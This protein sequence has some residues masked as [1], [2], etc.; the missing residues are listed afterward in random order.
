MLHDSPTAAPNEQNEKSPAPAVCTANRM[1]SWGET[2][3]WVLFCATSLHLAFLQP[4]LVIIPGERAKVLSGL[5]CGL[6]FVAA[7]IFSGRGSVRIN[8]LPALISAVLTVLVML[9]GLFSLTPESSSIRGF[10]IVTSALGGFWCA[11]LLLTNRSRQWQ[12]VWLGV[13]MLTGVIVL[14]LVG[15][16][17]AGR[18]YEFLDSHWHPIAD[19]VIL[20]SFAPLALLFSR[21]RGLVVLGLILLTLSYVVLLVGGKTAQMESAVFIPV[22]M[23]LLAVLLTEVRSSSVLRFSITLA[24]LFVMASTL[25]NHISYRSSNVQKGHLSVAYRVE[26]VFFS[27]EI[28]KKHPFLGNGLLA[29]R[30]SYLEDYELRYPYHDKDF[31]VKWTG[32]LRT[33]ENIF[34]TFMADFGL[35]FVIVYTVALLALLFMLLRRVFHPPPESVLPPLVILLPLAGALLHYQVLDGLVHPQLCWFFHVLLGLIP[36]S[37]AAGNGSVEKGRAIVLKIALFVVVVALGGLIGMWLP[38]GFPLRHLGFSL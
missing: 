10:T 36:T 22:A 28:V 34:L 14:A 29:P 8:R 6:S 35:P 31:F 2:A 11:R 23:L 33:S 26:N 27:W 12:Y 13:L 4:Y 3:A 15:Y 20:L 9:S 7:L 32:E 16:L 21:S 24:V 38:E 25:G 1:E 5:L 30:N 18:I 37:A 19:R 17:D